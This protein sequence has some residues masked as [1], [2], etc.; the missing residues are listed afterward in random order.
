MPE[1]K[2]ASSQAAK[3]AQRASCTSRLHGYPASTD[4]VRG[5][6]ADIAIMEEFAF[7]PESVFQTIVVPLLTITHTALLGISTPYAGSN[8]FFAR[9]LT[10]RDPTGKPLFLV[11]R[12][13]MMCDTCK[14]LPAKKVLS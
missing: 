5:C 1:G 8:D 12:I 11:H 14:K 7:M 10:L 6:S 2:G 9:L 13:E 3:N 4:S